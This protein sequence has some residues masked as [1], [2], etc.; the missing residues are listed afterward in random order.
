MIRFVCLVLKRR[1]I[2]VHSNRLPDGDESS[3]PRLSDSLSDNEKTDWFT[4]RGQI[5]ICF[6]KTVEL[7][8]LKSSCL[9][10]QPPHT[11][12]IVLYIRRSFFMDTHRQSEHASLKSEEAAS[13]IWQG[14]KFYRW[15]F[16][17]FFTD[18]IFLYK[19]DAFTDK[20]V[21]RIHFLPALS[22]SCSRKEEIRF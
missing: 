15:E 17:Y 13:F 6:V 20:A 8:F 9:R 3:Q 5:F 2:F 4:G 19:L 22:L 7:Q 16:L 18:S 14:D 10:R 12:Q 11:F 21:S 1:S